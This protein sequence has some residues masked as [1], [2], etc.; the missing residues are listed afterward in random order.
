MHILNMILYT[1]ITLGVLIFIHEFGHFITAKL[2]KMR[3]DRFSIGFPPR[4]FGKKIGDTDYCVSW[5]PIGGYVKIAG[6]VDES[7]DTDFLN[8]EPQP[9]E[10]R[11]KPMWARMLVIS[12]GVIMNVFLALIIFWGIHFVQG[13]YLAETTEVGYVV[14]DSYLDKAGLLAGDK[15]ISV[16]EKQVTRWDEIQTLIY[17]ENLGNDIK[18]EVSR[19]NQQVSIFIPAKD[20]PPPSDA[21]SAMM[22]AHTV[23]IIEGIDP[24]MPASKMGLLLGDTLLSINNINVNQATAVITIKSNTGKQISIKWKRGSEV[25]TGTT[26]VTDEG[27]IGIRIGSRYTG[28]SKKIQYS[29]VTAFGESIKD[30][31]QS[32][33]LFYLT[34]S[35]IFAGKASIKESLGGPIAIAQLA[36]QTAEYGFLMFIWFM[37]Q[38]SMSLA[39]L[40][41]L[42]IPAL[43]GGHLTIMLVEKAFRREI[44]FRVKIIIQQTGFILLLAFMAFIIYNDISRF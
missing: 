9:W 21:Q 30:I 32:I 24:N 1:A 31:E 14:K 13:T 16:N 38:L 42:P 12:G 33:Y 10:F 34:F 25:L 37:A 27:R 11:S 7:M 36:T 28:P 29:I 20:I 19:E 26:T 18:L 17:V 8:R 40:N 23:T 44:P 4:A 2:T 22:I 3:V 15:I 35:K 41:I 5:I 39:I 43:D 6:M